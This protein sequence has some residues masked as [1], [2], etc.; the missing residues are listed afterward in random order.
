MVQGQ[1]QKTEGE[2]MNIQQFVEKNGLTLAL[3]QH[4]AHGQT[5]YTANIFRCF[6]DGSTRLVEGRGATI[7][8]ARADYARIISGKTVDIRPL[9]GE[10]YSLAVPPLDGVAT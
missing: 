6:P 4:D 1:R 2:E 5:H 3:W 8:E 10:P 9:S 7:D